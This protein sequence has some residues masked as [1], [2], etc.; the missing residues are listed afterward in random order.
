MNDHLEI[1][2]KLLVEDLTDVQQRLK[3]VGARMTKPRIFERN[4]RYEDADHTLTSQGKL[5]RLRVDDRVRLTYKEPAPQVDELAAT[6]LELE[7]VVDN[8]ETM[9][10][11]LGRMGYHPYLVYEKYRTTY[12]LF[13]AEIVLDKLPYGNFVEIEGDPQ[14]IQRVMDALHLKDARPFKT[15]YITLFDNVKHHLQLDFHDLTFA[16][17]EGIDVPPSAF[18]FPGG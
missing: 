2:I 16:N 15:N 12:E 4:I 13:D 14:A 11:I 17:F 10:L 5:V 8:F 6:R 3:S 7:V 18:D 1:E 9:E